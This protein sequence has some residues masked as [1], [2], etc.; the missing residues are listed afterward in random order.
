M[1]KHALASDSP[2]NTLVLSR[3]K[4]VRHI[5]ALGLAIPGQGQLIQLSAFRLV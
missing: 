3:I 4:S 1:V 5:P 2:L